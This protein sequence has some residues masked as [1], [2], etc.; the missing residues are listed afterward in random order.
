MAKSNGHWMKTIR[1]TMRSSLAIIMMIFGG[2]LFVPQLPMAESTANTTDH[3]SQLEKMDVDSRDRSIGPHDHGHH[4]GRHHGDRINH[5]GDARKVGLDSLRLAVQKD[6]TVP[7]PSNLEA[8][9]SD[10]WAA[11]Q[12]GKALFWDMQVGSDGV[13]AC[14]SCHFHA[15]TDNRIK[16]AVNPD[17]GVTDSRVGDVI[18]YSTAGSSR[19]GFETKRP[20]ESL[21]REDFPFVKV[22]DV[23]TRMSDG[24]I[25]PG[26][27]NSNDIVGSMGVKSTRYD[28]LQPGSPLD[29]GT[30]LLD[31][32]FNRDGHITV[33]A[34]EHRNTP[35]VI[36]AVFNFTN[37]WDGRANPHFTGRTPFG[38]Q[39]Q[40]AAIL[41]NRS[42]IGLVA[43]HI[44]L[45]NASL[46]SQA[47]APPINP[48]EM[49]FGEPTIGNGRRLREL[50]QKLLRPG[51]STN[52][53]LTPLGGQ[54]VHPYDSVLGRLSKAPGNGLS[55]T[56]EAMIKRAFV[57]V[58]WNSKELTE[59]PSTPTPVNFTQMEVN[60]G[61]FFGLAIAMYEAT[62]VA[63]RTPFDEWMET[64]Q[65]NHGFHKKQLAG[66]NVFVNEGRC[67]HCHAGPELTN[68]SVRSAKGGQNLIRAM[69]MVKGT[70]LYDN[71]FYNL[72][73]TP[74]TDDIGRG[75][76][77]IFG[78]PLAF[79]RQALFDRLSSTLGTPRMSFPILGNAH[80]PAKDEDLGLP[81]CEDASAN[82]LCEPNELIRPNFQRVAADGAFKVPGL[83]NVELTGPY[84]HNG[85]MATLRQVVQ[86]YNRGGNFC[87]FN[88]SDIHLLMAPLQLTVEQE[89]Q[90][91][92][93]LVSLTDPRVKYQQAPFDHPALSIPRDGT[94][95]V[96]MLHIEAVGSGGTWSP[97]QSFLNLD[98][99]DPILTPR[100]QCAR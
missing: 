71:G 70:A 100:G 73:V 12:L 41:V 98:P 30:P 42:G 40:A 50:G 85:G 21:T 46:A 55:T 72:G 16:N 38:D 45:D 22:I 62:L 64:G 91:V 48:V 60:F 58:Y 31:P 24:T 2:T 53:P 68:A 8:F 92:A 65:F 18:G 14:A 4:P 74:T 56:Y 5:P 79:T 99:Q 26:A 97:L 90:L 3:P 89:E 37:F 76:T 34:I 10:R 94:D 11:I 28:G 84:F 47:V 78:Q 23:V 7:L 32:V 43:E 66:L 80:I 63:D 39:D 93:F 67:L 69:A 54:Y 75:D 83:R 25:A 19:Q 20:D 33:R 27:N 86:F 36:N 9:I 87:S 88:I 17:E 49:A 77:D 61:F 81:V 44:S 52:V 95:A 59:L 6:G 13:Q 57:D 82:G 29:L 15:G 1:I 96:G 35:S 51:T